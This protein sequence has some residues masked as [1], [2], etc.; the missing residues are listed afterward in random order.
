MTK[1]Y[2]RA[3]LPSMDHPEKLY[4]YRSLAGDSGRHVGRTLFEGEVYFGSARRFNDPFECLPALILDG[5]EAQKTQ[6]FKSFVSKI[7]DVP[8][9]RV[10]ELS[11]QLASQPDT[12]D[13]QTLQDTFKSQ[14]DAFPMLCLSAVADN[15][16]M[17]SHYAA[18]HSGVCL[19]FDGKCPIFEQATP[20]TYSSERVRI[21]VIDNDYSSR[22]VLL[23]KSLDWH[24]EQEWRLI[25]VGT[26][27][28]VR[29]WPPAALTAIILGARISETDR[30]R[31]MAWVARRSPK[32]AVRQASMSTK[33][34]K[35]DIRDVT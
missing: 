21:N 13:M 18:E 30:A 1:A 23:T 27:L 3:I 34:F 8:Q 24:Y 16:L 22:A 33:R 2:W 28:G 14:M 12:L 5:T 4:K 10:H 20:V 7:K 6:Y 19:E 9:E 15:V 17:W 32:I 25:E 29:I 31:V 26:S 35:V 11:A